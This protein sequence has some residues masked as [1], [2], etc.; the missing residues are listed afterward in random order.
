MNS[1]LFAQYLPNFLFILLRAGIVMSLLP[2]IGSRNFPAQFKIGI[3]VAIA[4]ILSPVVDFPVTRAGIPFVVM[5]E[6]IFGIAFGFAARFIFLAVDMA[7][8]LMSTSMGMSIATVF[9]PE[10]GQTTDLSQLYGVI[11]MLVFFAI[12]GHHDLIYVFV[13]SYEWL[14]GGQINI[15][16]LFATLVSITSKMFVIALKLS[17]PVVLGMVISNILLG[18]IYKV[19]PQINV[20]FVGY[21]VFMFVGFIILFFGITVFVNGIGGYFGTMK[22]ELIRVIE[23]AKG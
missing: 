20:F 23:A 19:A 3:A 17:A 22:G 14:P 16:N 21:P 15:A 10:V 5:H 8:Q 2:A 9:N 1:S 4:L 7:G 11:T 12:D 6:I 13:R 18:F